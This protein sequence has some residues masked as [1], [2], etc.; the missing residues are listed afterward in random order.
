MANIDFYGYVEE[1]RGDWLLRVAEP[2]SKLIE[3]KWHTISRTWRDVKPAYGSSLDLSVFLKGARV[4]VAGIERTEMREHDGKKYYDLQ[5]R[6]MSVEAA[7]LP[8]RTETPVESIGEVKSPASSAPA[9][10]SYDDIEP[11]LENDWHTA[12]LGNEPF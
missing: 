1:V 7:P 5:V 8:A 9:F 3:G 12:A 10:K 2:H 11:P 4:K 6:A